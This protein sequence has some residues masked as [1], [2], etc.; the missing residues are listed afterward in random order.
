MV[1]EPDFFDF[2]ENDTT[3]L[4]REP[5][6]NIAKMGELK[7]FSHKGFWHCMDTARDKQNLETLWASGNAPWK[8]W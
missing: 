1:F 7:G 2:L 4:E 3:F 8:I 6:E 5:L